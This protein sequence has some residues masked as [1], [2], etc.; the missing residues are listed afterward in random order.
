MSEVLNQAIRNLRA[1][2]LIRKLS[3]H[4]KYLSKNEA[5]NLV[6]TNTDDEAFNYAISFDQNFLSSWMKGR[7][8]RMLNLLKK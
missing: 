1:E 6:T 5:I 8:Y 3:M 2:V 7:L 4:N